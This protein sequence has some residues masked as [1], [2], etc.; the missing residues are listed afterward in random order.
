MTSW[1]DRYLDNDIDTIF[2]PNFM[3]VFMFPLNIIILHILMYLF[4]HTTANIP[5]LVTSAVDMVFI[6]WLDV[7]IITIECMLVQRKPTMEN[8]VADI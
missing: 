8:F 1:T 2:G 3:L 7:F 5:P 4:L 6:N